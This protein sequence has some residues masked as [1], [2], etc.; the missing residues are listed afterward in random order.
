MVSRQFATR[1][2]F[3]LPDHVFVAAYSEWSV[4]AYGPGLRGVAAIKIWHWQK[5]HDRSMGTLCFY[6]S[7][8]DRPI[9]YPA[10]HFT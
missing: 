10:V 1:S 5:K 6:A 9:M 3:S 2:V 8:L 4:S 7:G